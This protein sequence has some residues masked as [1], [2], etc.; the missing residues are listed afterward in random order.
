MRLFRLFVL[1]LM[2]AGMAL[3]LPAALAKGPPNRVLITGPGIG[4]EIVITDA[5]LLQWMALGK[6]DDLFSGD[7]DA[8]DDLDEESGYEIVRQ[9]A[10]AGGNF[11]TFD[12]IMYYPHPD[13]ELG[14]IHYVGLEHGGSEYD[15]RWFHITP[16]G[17][18]ILTALL[19]HPDETTCA[20]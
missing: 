13:G 20:V 15:G 4:G 10:I 9:Y 8:P 11:M 3:A 18:A 12:R 1:V 2:L 17:E 16:E 5:L 6:F 19:L 7:I 14:Y